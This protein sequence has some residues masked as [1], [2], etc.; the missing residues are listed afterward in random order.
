LRTAVAGIL[1]LFLPGP[2]LVV[3]LARMWLADIDREE[4]EALIAELSVEPV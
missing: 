4:L 3:V 2:V 1:D